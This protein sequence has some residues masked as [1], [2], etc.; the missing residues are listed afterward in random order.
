MNT[1]RFVKELSEGVLDD[2]ERS[3]R[4][5]VPV[6]AGM[7]DPTEALAKLVMQWPARD[8]R[9]DMRHRGTH[10]VQDTSDLWVKDVVSAVRVR[11]DRRVPGEGIFV[12]SIDF[13]SNMAEYERFNAVAQDHNS[14]WVEA[15]CPKDVV[16][17]WSG[18]IFPVEGYVDFARP[19]DDIPRLGDGSGPL[20]SRRPQP[21]RSRHATVEYR[22]SEG[23]GG[24][25]LGFVA[26]DWAGK[27]LCWNEE[28]GPDLAVLVRRATQMLYGN[29][30]V[31]GDD[32]PLS[33]GLPLLVQGRKAALCEKRNTRPTWMSGPV[34]S[35]VSA[36]YVEA[37]GEEFVG[38][39]TH[40]VL[41][42]WVPIAC[43][44]AMLYW[45]G[46]CINQTWGDPP[47]PHAGMGWFMMGE[48]VLCAALWISSAV[49]TRMVRMAEAARMRSTYL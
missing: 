2:V 33:D 3:R 21:V 42:F 16:D 6:A 15:G 1:S 36:A 19:S 10:E 22:A 24:W 49:A 29:P 35:G 41:G 17:P 9:M 14:T 47:G 25:T 48:V 32:G 4:R 7:R 23:R 31:L 44:I 18:D 46:H 8:V 30:F 26:R 37:R 27:V 12:S 13:P 28:S 34:K 39:V 20:D 11:E 40:M 43:V 5:A 45:A 38:R